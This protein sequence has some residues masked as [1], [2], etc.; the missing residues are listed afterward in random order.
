M[1]GRT[2]PLTLS[3]R[4]AVDLLRFTIGVPSH[5]ERMRLNLG[6]VAAA[7]AQSAARPRWM[8]IFVKAYAM[9]A[10]EIP[11]LRRAYL[12]L[13]RPHYYDYPTS[14][15]MF[16]L[17]RDHQGEKFHFN[18]T[19]KNPAAL[20]IAEIDQMITQALARP[21]AE[22]REYRRAV[23]VARLPAPLRR[24]L[25]WLGYNLGRQRPK[26]F[27]TFAVTTHTEGRLSGL[28]CAWTTR[29]SYGRLADDGTMDVRVAVDHRVIDG[30]TGERALLR[31]E[32]I[33]NGP[34]A[35]E[36]RAA[37]ARK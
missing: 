12:G 1:R 29:L 18:Y 13:P 28:L 27:G 16:L 30:P 35:E 31:L 4:L 9:V 21:I 34:I 5:T 11:D 2:K 32:A 26:Y 25:M 7:R 15:A 19:V 36:L 22:V 14:I 10:D 3:Q 37:P 23:R 20:P 8:T 33:L 6:A 17:D 24:F